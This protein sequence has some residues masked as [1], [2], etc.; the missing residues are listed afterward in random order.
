MPKEDGLAG[1]EFKSGLRANLAIHG[2]GIDSVG[3]GAWCCCE[4]FFTQFVP[5]RPGW[6]VVRS[7]RSAV[8]IARLPSFGAVLF[9]AILFE[10]V[11]NDLFRN[12]FS[13]ITFQSRSFAGFSR[14][15]KFLPSNGLDSGSD[16]FHAICRPSRHVFGEFPDF[17]RD[18]AFGCNSYP[19]LYFI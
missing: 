5:A 14:V 8:L 6:S 12:P 16:G 2:A 7:L 19:E 13:Y 18:T 9:E 4:H 15:L 1:I 3:L 17:R 11:S 10:V